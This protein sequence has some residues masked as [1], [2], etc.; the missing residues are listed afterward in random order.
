MSPVLQVR[1]SKST[2]AQLQSLCEQYQVS[3]S[4][5]ARAALTAFLVDP[6]PLLESVLFREPRIVDP[7]TPAQVASSESYVAAM[8]RLDVGAIIREAID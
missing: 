5:V 8:E 6:L 1:I 4:T 3:V 2:H 7:R